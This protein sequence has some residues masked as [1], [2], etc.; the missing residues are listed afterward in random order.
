M[1]TYGT[2]GSAWGTVTASSST[3]YINAYEEEKPKKPDTLEQW[4]RNRVQE[5]CDLVV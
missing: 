5:I 2:I 3:Y 1:A 4:L